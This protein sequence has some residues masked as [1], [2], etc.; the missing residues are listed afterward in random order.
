MKK[1]KKMLFAG[2]LACTMLATGAALAGCGDT[3]SSDSTPETSVPE[4]STPD[5]W[6]L[7]NASVTYTVDKDGV[8][9]AN[10]TV[11][12]ADGEE[13]TK[14]VATGRKVVE[15][16]VSS[17]KINGEEMESEVIE[18]TVGNEPKVEILALFDDGTASWVTITDEMYQGDKPDYTKAGL[19]T[20][21]IKLADRLAAPV[22]VTD[23]EAITVQSMLTN[24]NMGGACVL[25]TKADVVAGTYDVSTVFWQHY[26][27]LNGEMDFAVTNATADQ[28]KPIDWTAES[29]EGVYN[30]SVTNAAGDSGVLQ[31]YVLDDASTTTVTVQG[32]MLG[33]M[34]MM[35][36]P[37]VVKGSDVSAINTEGFLVIEMLAIGTNAMGMRMVEVP[38]GA[39]YTLDTTAVGQQTLTA[40]WT[41]NNAE[42]TAIASVLVY[43]NKEDSKEV[44]S[45]NVNSYEA[46]E[47][48]VADIE[49]E[50]YSETRYTA[51]TGNDKQVLSTTGGNSEYVALTAEMI[52]GT[53]PDFTTAGVKVFTIEVG[54]NE[55]T[56]AVELEKTEKAVATTTNIASIS[57]PEEIT[58]LKDANVEL[59]VR[60]NLVGEEVEITYIEPVNMSYYNYVMLKADAFDW[61]EVKTDTVGKYAIKVTY[62]GYTQEIAVNV[63]AALP[64][65]P[66][67]VAI[68]QFPQAWMGAAPVIPGISLGEATLYADG[69]A[70]ISY[71]DGYTYEQGVYAATYALNAEKTEIEFKVDGKNFV[72]AS[73]LCDNNVPVQIGAYAP[74]EA[75]TEITITMEKY[76]SVINCT[77]YMYANGYANF[78]D[79]YGNIEACGAAYTLENGILTLGNYKW[80]VVGTGA[81]AQYITIIQNQNG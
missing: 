41:E 68:L 64:E 59:Y 6:E 70:T 80:A 75:P 24:E 74:T 30:F 38:E 73:V 42:V 49:F 4:T 57:L 47:S 69:T 72:I 81:D 36:Q 15:L 20:A 55:Y 11:V 13:Y 51:G 32:R 1:A 46:V 67:L 61:S 52:K 2:F 76:G 78:A 16:D 18:T 9:M 63:I 12:S 33:S 44:V 39:T 53:A 54:G 43:E 21:N 45:I 8:E 28:I 40:T 56:Y 60:Q 7:G 66:E 79:G 25:W 10:Y 23:G 62:E 19:Y 3:S 17:V 31:A 37:T 26:T 22:L 29:A 34:T 58:L 48:G 50:I 77:L 35:E 14:S 5:P 71:R 27:Y 65:A